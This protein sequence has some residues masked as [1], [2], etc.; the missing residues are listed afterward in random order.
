[1]ANPYQM[2]SYPKDRRT[3]CVKTKHKWGFITLEESSR[4]IP[5]FI[6]LSFLLAIIRHMTIIIKKETIPLKSYSNIRSSCLKNLLIWMKV[7]KPQ[8]KMSKIIEKIDIIL[9]M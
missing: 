9:G 8:K 6:I 1:L 2:R 3:N 5:K 4:N 7:K